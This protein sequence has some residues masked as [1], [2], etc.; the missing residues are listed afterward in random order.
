MANTN[1]SGE[2]RRRE[3]RVASR[4]PE[5]G[6][7]LIITD[8]KET[9]KYFFDGLRDSLPVNI[10]KKIVIKVIEAK[11][12]KMIEKCLE[13]LA[14]ESQYR[15]AWIVFDRDRVKDFDEIIQEA[16]Q[17][18]I[19]VG[20]SNPCFEIWLYAYFGAMPVILESTKC[21]SDFRRVYKRI[22]KQ[23]YSKIDKNLY[24]K[25]RKVGDEEKAIIIAKQKNEQHR[26]SNK[27]KPSEMIP[28]TTV[29]ELVEEIS[30]KGRG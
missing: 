7:Y 11:T 26:R 12:S 16:E 4:V 9:E 30:K 22:T 19:R 2:R 5:L 29:H 15:I 8:T 17:K 25:L 10:Q 21:C 20:W 28:G 6:Y 3:H 14:Q 18:D 24:E 1:R 27:V 13:L 23:E